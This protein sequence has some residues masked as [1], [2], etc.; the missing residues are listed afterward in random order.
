[1]GENRG[2]KPVV[3]VR[4]QENAPLGVIRPV[5]EHDGRAELL[6]TGRNVGVQ[7]FRV[8]TKAYGLQFHFE[9]TRRFLR[10]FR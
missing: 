10:L 7:A 2:M 9:V 6:F 1:M 5:L 3:C 8:G 4:H